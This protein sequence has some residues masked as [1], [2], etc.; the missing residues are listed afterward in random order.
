MINHSSLKDNYRFLFVFFKR[1][2][3]YE[4]LHSAIAI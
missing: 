3:G 2:Y 1:F 4:G